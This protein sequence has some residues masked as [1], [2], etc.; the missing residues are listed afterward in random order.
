MTKEEIV[1]RINKLLD[2]KGLEQKAFAAYIEFNYSK[3]N[4]QLN[5]VTG[6]QTELICAILEKCEDV[7][8]EWLMRGKGKMI[9]DS[10]YTQEEL[11]RQ[12]GDLKTKLLVQ[13]GITKELKSIISIK[14]KDDDEKEHKAVV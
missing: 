4:N 5:L 3:L 6:L 11:M 7:S 2:Y 1:G 13:E 8:A 12:I 9:K 10:S 14:I